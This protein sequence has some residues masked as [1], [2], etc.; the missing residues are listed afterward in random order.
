MRVWERK[1]P[2]DDV[3]RSKPCLLRAAAA[4]SLLVTSS[5]WEAY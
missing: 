1:D 2:T 4:A 3:Y 5:V